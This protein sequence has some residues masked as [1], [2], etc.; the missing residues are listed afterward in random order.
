MIVDSRQLLPDETIRCD[1]CIVGGGAAGIALAYELRQSGLTVAVLESGGTK[2]E[3]E[4][5]D[6]SKGEVADPVSHGPLEEYRR[7]RLGGATTAWGGRC[8][9]FDAVDFTARSFVPHSGWPISKQEM[10]PYYARAHVYC[11]LGAYTYDVKH[12]LPAPGRDR[13][14]IP[15]FESEEVST[16]QLYLFS[17][18]T[19]FGKKFT[20]ELRGAASVTI[21]LYSNVLKIVTNPEGTAVVRVEAAS[22]PTRRHKVIAKQYVLAG[23]GLEV[24][25]LLLAS[26][27]VQSRGIGNENDAL[28]RFYM[29]H[30]IH[31]VNVELASADVVWDYEK[32]SGGAYCQRT[33]AVREE[34]QV[35]HG[36]LNHRARFEHPDISDPS[37]GSGVLSATYVAKTIL[38]SLSQNRFLSDQVNTLSKGTQDKAFVRPVDHVRNLMLDAGGV[39]R[40][41]RR[42][43]NERVLS[44]R[45]LPSVVLQSEANTYTLRIDAEQAPNPDSRLTLSREKDGL[46]MRRLRVDWRHTDLDVQSL[47]RTGE[48]LGEALVRSRAGT[49]LSSP[50]TAPKATGGHHIGTTRM[51]VNPREGVVDADCRVHGVGNL[52]IASSSVFPTS[53]YANP[54][55]TIVAMTLRLADHLKNKASKT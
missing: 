4:T 13:P 37:H 3:N 2:F 10:D 44:E 11:D 45:K 38:T 43:L 28:G 6:L 35:Q 33:L 42:W 40:F 36:V 23:G 8:V 47:R 53:S 1:V 12:A 27:D 32:T 29:C 52:F 39:F 31:H 22:S 50:E 30:V 34:F 19:N 25:R 14:M 7:R 54:T 5:H 46:G 18:P 48:L 26:D 15:G 17:P 20:D 21:F 41:S 16:D 55:L 51:A 49:V 9:P 24:T